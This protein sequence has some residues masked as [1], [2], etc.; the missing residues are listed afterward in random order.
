LRSAGS[1]A[2]QEKPYRLDQE[3]AHDSKEYDT[4][5]HGM[6]EEMIENGAEVGCAT[7]LGQQEQPQN[8]T[9]EKNK[10]NSFHGQI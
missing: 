1:L 2:R 10:Q 5:K 7:H 4:A 8:G 3:Q 6:K 9:A